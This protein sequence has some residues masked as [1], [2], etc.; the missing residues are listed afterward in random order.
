MKSHLSG[1]QEYITLQ[2]QNSEKSQS[3]KKPKLTQTN[4]DQNIRTLSIQSREELDL[5]FAQA[6]HRSGQP[7]NVVDGVNWDPFFKKLNPLY[8]RPGQ[9]R[10]GSELLSK[11]SQFI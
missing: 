8:S 6:I 4:L 10:I 1:C 3:G 11:S 7:F 5:L 9:D 2:R